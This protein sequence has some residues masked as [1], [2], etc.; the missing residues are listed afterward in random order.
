MSN[1]NQI[2]CQQAEQAQ[3]A[4]FYAYRFRQSARLAIKLGKRADAK[5]FIRMYRDELQRSRRGI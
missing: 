2:N 4:E 1:Q 3:I 5:F